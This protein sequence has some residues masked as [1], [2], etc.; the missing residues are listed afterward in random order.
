MLLDTHTPKATNTLN[1][2]PRVDPGARRSVAKR[3]IQWCAATRWGV[4]ATRS[5][6]VPLDTFLLRATGGRAGVTMG[7]AP[8]AVLTS[9]GARSGLRRETPLQY[10]T[11][12]DD[13]ILAASNFGGG[14]HP[15]WYHNLRAHPAC[16]LRVGARG[17]PFTAAEVDD[18]EHARLFELATRLYPGYAR[19]AERTAG[20]RSIG[21]FRLTTA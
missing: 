19:C 13:V 10:F 5:I 2:I 1:G 18:V 15:G 3:V 8:V 16:E 21:I 11:D 6:A 12:G 17:G 4:A 7:A 9:L 20:V 14:R